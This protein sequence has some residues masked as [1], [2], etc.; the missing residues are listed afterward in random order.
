MNNDIYRA[1]QLSLNNDHLQHQVNNIESDSTN[2]MTWCNKDKGGPW[3]L[4]FQLNFIRNAR[5]QQ[6]NINIIHK[7]QS[8][9]VVADFFGK[10]MYGF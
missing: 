2:A 4:N 10:E 8:P 5:K 7:R 1:N 6:M 3:N 9:N